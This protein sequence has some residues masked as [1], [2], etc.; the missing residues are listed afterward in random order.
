[1]VVSKSPEGWR[2]L[3]LHRAHHGPEFDGEWAWTPPAG[4]RLPGEDVAACAARELE[5]ESG[6]RGTPK[7]LLVE[8]VEWAVFELVVPW[9]T[10][11]SVDGVEHDRHEWVTL[12]E[13]CSRCLPAI[14]AESLRLAA[15]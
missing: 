9:G 13:A 3:I 7:P 15:R 12:E 5:E 11:I 6:L 4:A 8:D 10:P 2:Y 14:V 1:V